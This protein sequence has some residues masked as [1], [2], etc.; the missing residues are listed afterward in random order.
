MRRVKYFIAILLFTSNVS[1]GQ[2]TMCDILKTASISLCKNDY[3]TS[4]QSLQTFIKK[5]PKH[6]LIEEAKQELGSLYLLVGEIDNSIK[7]SLLIVNGKELTDNNDFDPLVCPTNYDKDTFKCM[8]IIF[9]EEYQNLQHL[10]CVDLYKCYSIKREYSKALSYLKLASKEYYYNYYCGNGNDMEENNIAEKFIELY[11]LMNKP[12]SALLEAIGL[13]MPYNLDDNKN[14]IDSTISLI[15]SRLQTSYIQK[16][17]DEAINYLSY[18]IKQ[19]RKF[20]YITFMNKKIY[21]R[22]PYQPNKEYSTE[23]IKTYIKSSYFYKQ[24]LALQ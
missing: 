17:F 4:I 24:L 8:R 23:S 18:E 19:D 1:L 21:I 2:Q 14:L 12:D 15:K 11:K 6:P 16:I 22:Y 7:Y 10:A 13:C 3:K 20:Y 9:P 5:Y